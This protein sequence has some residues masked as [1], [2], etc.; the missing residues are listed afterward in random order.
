MT[1][2]AETYDR[3]E[4]SYLRLSLAV[5]LLFAGGVV[6]ALGLLRV[7]TALFA[8]VGLAGGMA[9]RLAA[10]L[11]GV[12]AV[13]AVTGLHAVVQSSDA[14]RRLGMVGVALVALALGG[15]LLVPDLA[16]AS[17]VLYA[18]GLLV[19][20]WSVLAPATAAVL[21][22]DRSAVPTGPSVSYVRS[23][24]RPPATPADGGSTDDDVKPLLDDE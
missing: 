8:A 16:V 15:F 11:T 24:V 6:G 12:L 22:A 14:D 17:A 21:D 18:V 5:G 10:T 2:L 4:V 7:A 3:R 13:V 9:F 1:S 23:G 20:A 19:V